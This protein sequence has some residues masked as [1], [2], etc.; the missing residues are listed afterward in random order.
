MESVGS[1]TP[2][3]GRGRSTVNQHWRAWPR[4][5]TRCRNTNLGERGR[6]DYPWLRSGGGATRSPA[7][8]K[9]SG[10]ALRTN[11][12]AGRAW[13]S[14]VQIGTEWWARADDGQQGLLPRRGAAGGPWWCLPPEQRS[15]IPGSLRGRPALPHRSNPAWCPL[16]QGAA[17][18]AGREGP[19]LA[20]PRPFRDSGPQGGTGESQTDRPALSAIGGQHSWNPT[21]PSPSL[22]RTWSYPV[23]RIAPKDPLLCPGRQKATPPHCPTACPTPPG[24]LR[25]LSQSSG[26]ASDEGGAGAVASGDELPVGSGP[27]SGASACASES[28]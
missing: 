18:A 21:S 2:A 27:G 14:L 13:P 23:A 8:K 12:D 20:P 7:G 3:V 28:A 15:P 26:A 6:S 17:R 19:V 11:H 24:S 1:S 22:R 25:P 4:A 5:T 9:H 10:S 16:V